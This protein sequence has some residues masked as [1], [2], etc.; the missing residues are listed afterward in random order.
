MKKSLLTIVLAF[1]FVL[2]GAAFTLLFRGSWLRSKSRSRA[3]F[4]SSAGGNLNTNVG[5]AQWEPQSIEAPKN[6]FITGKLASAGVSGFEPLD[7][8]TATRWHKTNITTG[9]L[10]ITWNLTAQ[11]RTASWDYYITKMAGIPI[12]H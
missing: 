5:R 11:H 1:S 3:F 10:D 2:G 8:Q 4:G 7:E 12:N 9:P 6:T